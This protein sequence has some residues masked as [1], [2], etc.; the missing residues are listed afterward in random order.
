MHL[1]DFQ[2][3]LKGRDNFCITS[4][5]PLCTPTHFR[6]G[7]CSK[8]KEFAPSGVKITFDKVVPLED[9]SVPLN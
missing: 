8:K 1:L 2:H 4:C 3:I 9:I 7:V 6:K 5:L